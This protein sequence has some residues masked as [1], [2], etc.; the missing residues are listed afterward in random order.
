MRYHWGLGIGHTYSHATS[1]A[2]INSESELLN[3]RSP[4]QPSSPGQ[5]DAGDQ[6]SRVDDKT[7]GSE[8]DLESESE[9]E[10]FDDSSDESQVDFESESESVLADYVDMD[11]WDNVCADSDAFGGYEF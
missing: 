7:N 3:T 11:G 8:H 5:H 2:A 4:R 1:I 6:T 9:S 10:I